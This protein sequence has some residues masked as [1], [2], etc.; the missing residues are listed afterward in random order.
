MAEAGLVA[1]VA[2][3]EIDEM[4]DVL[5]SSASE[6]AVDE[7]KLRA[8]DRR[9]RRA[10]GAWADEEL[11]EMGRC[12]D[13]EDEDEEEE[14]EGATA[15]MLE[16]EDAWVAAWD[17]MER[18]RVVRLSLPLSIRGWRWSGQSETIPRRA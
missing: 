5:L 4:L 17:L 8:V 12:R 18:D 13:E 16:D 11:L 6:S 9:G 2:G 1:A 7:L 14:V 3:V 10:V 15:L